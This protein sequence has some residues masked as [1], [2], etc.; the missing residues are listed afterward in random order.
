MS[1]NGQSDATVIEAEPARPVGTAAAAPASR[2]ERARSSAYRLRFALV[3]VFLAVA[4]G[5]AVGSFVVLATRPDA[6][7]EQRWSSFAPDGSTS[8][9]VKQI[10]DHVSTRY[11]LPS[12]NQLAAA[13]GGP[14][15]V[16]GGESG[17]IPV[18]AIIVRPDTTTGRAEEGEYRVVQARDNV[19]YILCGLGQGCSIG[20]GNASPER[21][22][23]LRREALELALYTFKHVDDVDSVTVLLPPPPDAE[24]T[25][26]SVFLE[27]GDVSGFLKRPLSE[28]LAPKAPAVGKIAPLELER[29]QSA[30][31]P[32][33][34]AYEYQQAQDLS[35]LLVLAQI[36][37]S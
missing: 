5:A 13:W 19:M 33:L 16:S 11:R 15:R 1:G 36:P 37:P 32:A 10:A 6:A 14:P 7:P 12:G 31:K 18:S 21:L 17:D 28:T 23:L 35:A 29:V 9:K 20:E 2:A 8:A 3:Y 25:P 22:A 34:Y 4:A 24:S 26:V 27:R 30:T